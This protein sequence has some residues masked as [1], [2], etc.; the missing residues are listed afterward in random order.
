MTPTDSILQHTVPKR[1]GIVLPSSNS[2]LEPLV[3]RL[4]PQSEAT[5]HFSRLGVIDITLDPASLAQFTLQ[6]Q[7]AV[8]ALLCDAEVD[9]V[10][11]GGTS[12][13]WLGVDH[14]FEFCKMFTETTGVPAGSCVLEINRFLASRRVKTFGLVTPYTTEVQ[15]KIIDNYQRLGFSC[16][17]EQHYGGAL[18]N[19][20]ATI[21]P[22]VIAQ[23]VRDVATHAP[24]VILIMCT[25]MFGATIA[26]PLTA[27]TGIPVIDSAAITL[28]AGLRLA[29]ARPLK[30][31]D[32]P[33][34]LGDSEA[35][36]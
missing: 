23:M 5:F 1:I 16:V 28:Q 8:G 6:G 32:D 26:A 34:H 15:Q 4:P 17:G 19:D 36:G 27:E 20:Y 35:E 18:S 13:S 11:W 14:D 2:V 3:A 7:V 30:I 29:K 12:A 9:C 21:D 31:L 10:V 22:N 25:N 33:L 24:D